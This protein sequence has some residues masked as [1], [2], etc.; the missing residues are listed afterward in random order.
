MKGIPFDTIILKYY[1]EKC[2]GVQHGLHYFGL[3]D[4]CVYCFKPRLELIKGE[5]K[6]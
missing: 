4:K 2:T 1:K 5:K 3:E 6:C